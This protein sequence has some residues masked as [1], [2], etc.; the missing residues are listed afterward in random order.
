MHVCECD[1]KCYVNIKFLYW[2]EETWNDG[3]VCQ[4]ILLHNHFNAP[5]EIIGQRSC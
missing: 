3:R 4:G 2:N 1:T 5:A